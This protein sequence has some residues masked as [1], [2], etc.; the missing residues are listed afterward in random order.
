MVSL[1]E[2]DIVDA[3]RKKLVDSPHVYAVADAAFSGM[4]Q[5]IFMVNFLEKK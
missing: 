1:Y 3:Y 5:G 4:L 2:S